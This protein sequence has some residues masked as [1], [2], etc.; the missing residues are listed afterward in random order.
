MPERRRATT[1]DDELSTTIMSGL[2]SLCRRRVARRRTAAAAAAPPESCPPPKPSAHRASSSSAECRRETRRS[3]SS[4]TVEVCW[5]AAGQGRPL[6]QTRRALRKRED[7]IRA[8]LCS[9]IVSRAGIVPR[10]RQRGRP[11]D[12]R[13]IRDR[14]PL[15]RGAAGRRSVDSA[16]CDGMTA[17]DVQTRAKKGLPDAWR[18]SNLAAFRAV[19]DRPE[20]LGVRH[21]CPTPRD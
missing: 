11:P 7:A 15:R 21:H 5:L 19:L 6:S 10:P 20:T 4:S 12:T 9:P 16:S 13:T 3:T 18:R 14:R 17:G 2:W 8:S 1:S